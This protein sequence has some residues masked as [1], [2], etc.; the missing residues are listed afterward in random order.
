MKL[1]KQKTSVELSLNTSKELMIQVLKQLRTLLIGGPLCI[2]VSR[3]SKKFPKS[4][5]QFIQ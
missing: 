2:I 4:K 3:L 5:I 1:R